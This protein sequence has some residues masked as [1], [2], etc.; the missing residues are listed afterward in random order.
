MAATHQLSRKWG[1]A[2]I[3]RATALSSESRCVR[4]FGELA[5]ARSDR[6]PWKAICRQFGIARATAHRRWQYGVERDRVE[7]QWAK[8]AEEA[9]AAVRDCGGRRTLIDLRGVIVGLLCPVSGNCG[10]GQG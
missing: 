10:N 2:D 5:W 4:L 6:T 7:A 3:R 9:G 8:G 1:I